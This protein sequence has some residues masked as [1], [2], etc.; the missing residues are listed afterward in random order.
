[1]S[2]TSAY[3]HAQHENGDE[4]EE[5]LADISTD[6]SLLPRGHGNEVDLRA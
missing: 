5:Q 4:E 6:G 2:T 3:V 1:M